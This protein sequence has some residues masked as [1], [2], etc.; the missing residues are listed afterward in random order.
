MVNKVTIAKMKRLFLNET[1]SAV[2]RMAR[3]KPDKYLQW[4]AARDYY[5]LNE[6]EVIRVAEILKV[7]PESIATDQGAPRLCPIEIQKQ[8]LAY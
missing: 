4:E 6:Q 3:V 7:K 2:A 8:I 5:K 1:A